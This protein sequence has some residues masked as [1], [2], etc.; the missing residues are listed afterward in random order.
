M[1]RY[2]K[3]KRNKGLFSPFKILFSP[4]L[5]PLFIVVGGF[6]FFKISTPRCPDI[7][8]H[9]SIFVLTGDSRRIPFALH[10]LDGH[11]YRRLYV[12]GAGLRSLDTKFHSQVTIENSSKTTY[13]NALAIKKIARERLLSEIVVV[14]TVDHTNRALFLIKQQIP[15]VKV[16]A[17]PVPLSNM[18]AQKRLQRWV[19]EYIK[20]I[21]TVFGIAQKA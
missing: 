6:G 10:K 14:T 16:Q 7:P 2:Q 1:V 9:A 15:Y 13:E 4:Y 18:P 11:P 17:C 3:R 8:G 19:E 5:L 20:F 12:I 21:G